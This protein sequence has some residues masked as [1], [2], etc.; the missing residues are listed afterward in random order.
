MNGI[1]RFARSSETPQQDTWSTVMFPRFV[2]LDTSLHGPGDVSCL[3]PR[4]LIWTGRKN[5]TAFD[6][7]TWL[8][9]HL[10]QKSQNLSWESFLSSCFEW[11]PERR[12]KAQELLQY[13]LFVDVA[14]T[15]SAGNSGYVPAIE[16]SDAMVVDTPALSAE[17]L[18]QLRSCV[19]TPGYALTGP[20]SERS[21][22]FY[23]STKD[24]SDP[25]VVTQSLRDAGYIAIVAA[26]NQGKASPTWL[27]SAKENPDR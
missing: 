6:L 26:G 18:V 15:D 21:R 8:N 25:A 24:Y 7:S 11:E 9:N 23:K 1:L 10:P 17:P 5:K 16:G 4:V 13:Q 27:C 2:S 3:P 20:G 22:C 14:D 19:N 12:P